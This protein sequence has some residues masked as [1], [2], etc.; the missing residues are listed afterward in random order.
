[1]KCLIV[2]LVACLAVSAL[3]DET[4]NTMCTLG[5]NNRIKVDCNTCTCTAANTVMGATCS[6]M[7][8][9]EADKGCGMKED[10]VARV[11]GEEWMMGT[12][13]KCCC[14]NMDNVMKRVCSKVT[15]DCVELTTP[16]PHH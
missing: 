9:D 16:A 12:C 11:A 8:C 10:G 2:A 14:A 4:C 15:A 7:N 5:G 3:A 6:V 13:M 1:M